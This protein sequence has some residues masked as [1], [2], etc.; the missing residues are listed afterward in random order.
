MPK[1]EEYDKINAAWLQRNDIAI[2]WTIVDRNKVWHDAY[3]SPRA[4]RDHQAKG[5]CKFAWL[6]IKQM[7]KEEWIGPGTIFLDNMCG[8][9]SFLIVAALKGYDAIG[10]ELEEVFV[11]DMVGF[12]EYSEPKEDND[13]FAN[14][15]HKQ[16][17]EGSIERFHKLTDNVTKAGKI[18]VF[19]GDA[20]RIHKL[21]PE[22]GINL[23][24]IAVHRID[25]HNFAV[26]NSPPYSSTTEVGGGMAKDRTQHYSEDNIARAGVAVVNSPPYSRT[27]EHDEAQIDALPDNVG[28]HKPFLYAH[29][30]N[31]A[32]LKLG[33]YQTQMFRVYRALFKTVP[34]GTPV[35][36]LTRNFIQEGKVVLLDETTVR[37]MESAG[38]TYQYT[39]RAVLPEVSFFKRINWDKMHK[40]RGLPLILWEEATFYLKE[41][42]DE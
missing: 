4:V 42:D 23:H 26:V 21:L 11:A 17:I 16:H 25:P 33:P 8:I 5:N 35:A 10:V 13:L 29:R 24:N 3:F 7:E 6:I 39:K 1:K 19:Q 40:A 38:F 9:G 2:D 15:T 22:H 14:Y 31:I 41:K 30:S 20:R 37:L 28:G 34:V 18:Q 32:R 12:D 36:L 27:T